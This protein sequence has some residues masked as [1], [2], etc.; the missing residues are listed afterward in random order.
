MNRTWMCG[1]GSGGVL[2]Y[3]SIAAAHLLR[4]H[5]VKAELVEQEK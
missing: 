3:L 5:A 2:D 4:V 1:D